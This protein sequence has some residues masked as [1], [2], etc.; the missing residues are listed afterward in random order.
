M[1]D[2]D[3]N[4]VR[5]YL[6]GKLPGE[7]ADRFEERL[8]TSDELLR[9][10]GEQQNELIDDYLSGNL[11]AQ[12]DAVFRTQMERSTTLRNKVEVHHTLLHAL[13][14]RTE[15]SNQTRLVSRRGWIW[16]AVACLLLAV[17]GGVLRQRSK[18]TE[19]QV[20]QVGTPSPPLQ[21]T[22][23]VTSPDAVFFLSG[24]VTRGLNALPLLKIPANAKLVELQVGLPISE[25]AV[26]QWKLVNLDGRS[27]ALATKYE[28]RHAGAEVY[29]PVELPAHTLP[30]GDHTLRLQA[31]AGEA[32]VLRQ[33]RVRRIASPSAH[34]HP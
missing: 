10:A 22:S 33:F 26:K 11:N 34:Q 3:S 30:D 29:V 2:P 12:E 8:F 6:L 18:P 23:P 5:D 17:T 9:A 15:G 19:V 28:T 31:D 27:P 16:F 32:L 13:E 25:E 14:R 21:H 7:A 24:S 4:E 1:S 20:A